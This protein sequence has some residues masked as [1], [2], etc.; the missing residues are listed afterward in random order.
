[1]SDLLLALLSTLMATNTPAATSNLIRQ[2][3][4]ITVSIPDPNDPAE[5]EF[6]RVL[7]LDDEA[8]AEVDR[9]IRENHAFAEQGG[10]LSNV[11]LNLKILQRFD[12]VRTNYLGFLATHTNHARAYLAYA[13]FLNDIGSEEESVGYMERACDLDPANPAAWNNLA[14]YHGHRGD[15][16]KSFVYYA[17]AIELNPNEP[18]YYHNYG[19]TVFLFRKDAREHFG[20]TEQEVFDKALSLYAEAIRRDPGNFPLATDI[21]QSYYGIK[22]M[23]TNEAFTAWNY[24]MSVARD[25]IER[26]GVHLHLAR[27]NR[28]IGHYDEARRQLGIITNAMYQDLKQRILTSVNEK[29][30]ASKHPSDGEAPQEPVDAGPDGAEASAKHP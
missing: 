29:E 16:K 20:I 30:E 26:D 12:V 25:Q 6:R 1:M 13:S 27:W 18:I 17:R 14:N 22:P 24:A 10:G 9:W 3:T 19:T 15:V 28:D 7:E 11:E 21:A 23:R 2:Q 4:G 5:R 8:Q